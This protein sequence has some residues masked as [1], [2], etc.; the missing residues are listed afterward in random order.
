MTMTAMTATTLTSRVRDLRRIL[1]VSAKRL[2]N[3]EANAAITPVEC[4]R[5][6]DAS[7]D[8]LVDAKA[9]AADAPV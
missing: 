3:L 6:S 9:N 8:R 2:A 1:D 4:A 5:M 7:A